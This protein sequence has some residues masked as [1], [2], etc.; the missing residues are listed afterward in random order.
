MFS[1]RCGLNGRQVRNKNGSG[2][3]PNIARHF[4][5]T[6][7]HISPS[8]SNRAHATAQTRHTLQT[9]LLFILLSVSGK[10]ISADMY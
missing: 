7:H 1:L 9:P 10:L 6:L 4:S 3:C 2:V 8:L 5:S